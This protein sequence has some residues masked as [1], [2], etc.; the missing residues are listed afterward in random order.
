MLQFAVR[1][2]VSTDAPSLGDSVTRSA[3]VAAS[4]FLVTLLIAAPAAIGQALPAAEAAP[5]STGFSVPR[6]AGTLNYG[7]SASESVYWGYNGTP[8]TTSSTNLTGDLG[9]ISNSKR[10]PFST[11]FSGGYSWGGGNVPAYGFLSLGLS[12]VINVGRWDFLI[13]DSLS[14]LPGTPTTGLSGVPGVGDLGIPPVQV[15]PDTGQGILTNYSNRVENTVSGSLQRQITGKTSING[16]GSYSILRFLDNSGSTFNSG[17]DT[18]TISGGAGISHQMNARNT[19]GGNYAY[20]KNTFSGDTFGIPAQGFAS[21]TASVQYSHKFSPKLDVSL[22]GGP[23]WS[24][25]GSGASS[26]SV[27]LYVN[28]SGQYTGHFSHASL[29]YTRGTNGGYGVV[30]GAL[31]DSI[32]F[33]AGR[34]IAR[35]WSAAVSGA[36]SRN[37]SLPAQVVAPYTFNT[38]VGSVQISR[39]IVRS[40]S[41]YASYTAE[42][43]SNTNSAAAVDVFSGFT[44][45]LGFG[46]TYSPSSIHLGR[47]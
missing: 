13:S 11:V 28:V 35:V 37:T 22:G 12:Q 17:L 14:Y 38:T 31:S 30:G 26:Q 8:G 25:V 32:S 2:S 41:A 16:T 44:Q 3:I 19:W 18:S 40:L 5:I 6:A 7:V 46:L 36:Y 21:Q 23:Q 42:N 45:V 1:R 43:Q 15:V 4:L 33:N 39:A 24:S 47:Q 27:G 10:D 20:S 9:Y 29:A 34:M